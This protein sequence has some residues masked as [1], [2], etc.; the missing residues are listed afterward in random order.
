MKIARCTPSRGLIHSWTEHAAEVARSE[1]EA[2]GHE[3]RSFFT[4][5]LPIPDC[6]NDICE[7]AMDAGAD[8]I[9]ILEEDVVPDLGA[10]DQMLDAIANGAD[11]AL[12]D[13]TVDAPESCC[14][15]RGIARDGTKRISWGP[16]GCILIKRM[17]FDRL[18]RPWFTRR[19]RVLRPSGEI[20]WQSDTPTVYG[21]D[22]EF[23]HALRQMG[24]N[25]QEVEAKCDHL[26]IIERG[27]SWTND[28]RHR[29][30]PLPETQ[31]RSH[32]PPKAPL[33]RSHHGSS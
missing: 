5:D 14:F 3:F 28:G 15:E 33:R 29:I 13:Y 17:C 31:K 23:T 6:F 4:H 32:V 2:R 12:I 30:E 20:T 10:F 21:V 16:T 8:L 18:P 25:L 7:R 11:I 27:Q 1:A 19:G 9:W 26:R 22:V 24:F